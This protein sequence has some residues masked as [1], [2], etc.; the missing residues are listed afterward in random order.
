M[1]SSLLLILLISFASCSGVNRAVS[2]NE[3]GRRSNYKQKY[4]ISRPSYVAKAHKGVISPYRVPSKTLKVWIHP[5]E[6]SQGH[7]FHGGWMTVKIS[8]EQWSVGRP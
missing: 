1:R 8:S 3:L 2:T 6:T 4:T 5:H 7:Y